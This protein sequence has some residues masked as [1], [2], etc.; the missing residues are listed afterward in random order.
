MVRLV[1]RS[2]ARV[3]FSGP[4]LGALNVAS[5]RKNA[6]GRISGLLLNHQ[7][8]FF[9]VVE[10]VRPAVEACMRRVARDQRHGD[11]TVLSNS[12]IRVRA[13][14]GWRMGVAAP[15]DVPAALRHGM[16]SIAELLPPDS[17]LRGDVP[18]VRA[19]VRTFLAGFATLMPE[20]LQRVG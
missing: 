3:D 19:Q 8:H 11:I 17:A 16:F 1:Y 5:Q 10:G 15:D 13:F 14:E 20:P 7:G 12:K 2:Q 9:G 6:P 4:L 18:E